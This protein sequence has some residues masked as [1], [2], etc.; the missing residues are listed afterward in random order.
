M[1]SRHSQNTIEDELE[2]WKESTSVQRS[3]TIGA[4]SFA[5]QEAQAWCKQEKLSSVSRK[6]DTHGRFYL[7]GVTPLNL[8]SPLKEFG[9]DTH[10]VTKLAL[11]TH[12][13]SIQS[14]SNLLAPDAPLRSF[15]FN[16]HHQYQGKG[17]A[18]N[19]SDHHWLCPY[20]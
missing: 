11:K 7:G 5:P 8:L 19:L 6:K 18:S 3:K 13:H 10:D 15:F 16:S 14:I 1:M 17:S 4:T 2:L 12:A 20:I 9:L